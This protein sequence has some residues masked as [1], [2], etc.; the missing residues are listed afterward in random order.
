MKIKLT[1]EIYIRDN[2]SG[3]TPVKVECEYEHNVTSIASLNDVVDILG[4]KLKDVG[5]EEKYQKDI[6]L[7]KVS[8][9][10]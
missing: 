9:S 10:E 7:K 2:I 8:I 5:Y 6:R 1:A 4:D 3:K